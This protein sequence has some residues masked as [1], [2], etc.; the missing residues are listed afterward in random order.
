MIRP[1]DLGAPVAAAVVVLT[2]VLGGGFYP[3]PRLL[4]GVALIVV[5]AIATAGSSGRMDQTEIWQIA[6]VAWGV[7]SAV[8]VGASPLASKETLAIWIT[9]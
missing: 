6:F 1:I 5:W 3:L 2:A 8:L 9:A 4:V 7:V